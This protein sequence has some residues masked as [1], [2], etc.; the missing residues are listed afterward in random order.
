MSVPCLHAPNR[1][2]NFSKVFAASGGEVSFHISTKLGKISIRSQCCIVQIQCVFKWLKWIWEMGVIKIFSRNHPRQ[3]HGIHINGQQILHRFAPSLLP[4]P[5][6][7]TIRLRDFGDDIGSV[8]LMYIAN[9]HLWRPTQLLFQTESAYSCP[10][11]QRQHYLHTVS[12]SDAVLLCHPGLDLH[13]LLFSINLARVLHEGLLI[14][15][16]TLLVFNCLSNYNC[17]R[18]S[19][20]R[21]NRTNSSQLS[22][23][24]NILIKQQ[25]L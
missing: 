5:R 19:S 18:K 15:Q 21:L 10:K 16:A 1:V 8:A 13:R 11:H 22:N 20:C 7:H 4:P 12:I 14:D 3:D 17:K 25:H 6:L 2:E 23:F 9:Y 24:A